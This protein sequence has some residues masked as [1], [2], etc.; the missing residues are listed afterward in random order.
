[1][2]RQ[3]ERDREQNKVTSTATYLGRVTCRTRPKCCRSC[4]T[5]CSSNHLFSLLGLFR[6]S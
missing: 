4:R 3:R 2:L 6:V 5:Q 1:V